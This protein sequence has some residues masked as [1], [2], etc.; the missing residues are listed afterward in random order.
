[1]R[2]L[3]ADDHE[4]VRR[5]LR[6]LLTSRAGW[7]ICGEAA[8]GIEAVMK[9]KELRPDVILLDITMPELNGLDAAR[10]IRRDDPRTEI[11]ILSQYDPQEM[12]A[13][14]REVGARDYVCKSDVAAGLVV[15]LEAIEK[16]LAK[17]RSSTP[18]INGF[19]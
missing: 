11:V 8:N 5:G 18:K 2:I 19:S 4:L 3:I 1:M 14:A 12:H 17:R 15:A 9:A 6:S 16:D 13:R 7:E 10:L